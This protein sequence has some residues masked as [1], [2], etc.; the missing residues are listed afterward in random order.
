MRVLKHFPRRAAVSGW[1]A[2]TYRPDMR[3]LKRC[4]SKCPPQLAARFNLSTRHEGTETLCSGGDVNETPIASTYRPDMRVLKQP[5]AGNTITAAPSFNLSTR[6]EGT[7]TRNWLI[8][9]RF[10]VE[11]FNL[12]TR[13]EGTETS[14]NGWIQSGAG[15]STYR[16]D[17]RVLKL[18]SMVAIQSGAGASTYRP[19]MRVLKQTINR[20]S[21]HLAALQPIDPT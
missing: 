7:E 11:R 9:E 21:H 3:V 1:T 15:A 18:V 20:P 8:Y 10:S 14:I 19:D 17:M 6:H 12:S 2:S 5:S 13:H 16:P 4:G